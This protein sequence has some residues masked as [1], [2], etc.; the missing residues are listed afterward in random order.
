[1]VKKF[2][3][4]IVLCFTCAA[5]ALSATQARAASDDHFIDAPSPM[6]V[7]PAP[8]LSPDGTPGFI[9]TDDGAAPI[10][11]RKF[12][13]KA[14]KYKLVHQ[15]RPMAKKAKPKPDMYSKSKHY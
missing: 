4:L 5:S 1:M 15:Y 6:V 14:P 8:A 13:L 3:V 12:F 9:R 10:P 11:A 7:A 2:V